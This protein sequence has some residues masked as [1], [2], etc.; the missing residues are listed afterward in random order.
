MTAI[1]PGHC[2]TPMK[3]AYTRKSKYSK[4]S[5]IRA[6]PTSKVVKYEYGDLKKS[7]P[8]EVNLV[9]KEPMQLRHNAIESARTVVIRRLD[10]LGANYM[11]RIRIVPHHVLRENKM[12]SGAGADRLQKGM[13]K[14]FGRA[15][16]LAA[17]VKKGKT[18][19]S[20]YVNKEGIATAKKALEAATYRL[21]I[22]SVI[23]VKQQ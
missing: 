23:E 10:S 8:V 15:I 3:R 7:F 22:K 18:I 13:Q 19:F 11:M 6:P 17:Q 12:I 21:P 14:S 16:G 1:R 20:V 5:F 9:A 4:L 2:Y